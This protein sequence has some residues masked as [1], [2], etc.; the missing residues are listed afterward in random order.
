MGKYLHLF[1]TENEFISAYTGDEYIEP[2]VSYCLENSGVSFNKSEYEKLLGTPLTFN[3]TSPGTIKW[4]ATFTSITRTIEYKLNDGEWAS[5]TSNTG[6]SAPTITVKT[7]D[8]VQFRGN[9]DAY[10]SAGNNGYNTFSGTTAGFELEGNIMSLINKTKYDTLIKLLYGYNF[11]SLFSD[12]NT[13]ISAENL[14]LPAT[15]LTT[16]CY[17]NMFYNCTSLTTPPSI[18]PATT[19][20]NNCYFDMFMSCYS[21]TTAPA[22]PAT[23]LANNCYHFMFLGCTSLTTAP[24]LPA[25]TLADYCYK[26]MFYNCTS[27]TTAPELPATTL[28]SNCYE[29]MFQGCTRLN[30]IKCLATN[31]SANNCVNYWVQGVSSTGT[32]IKAAS[33]SS[34]TTGI[35]GIPNG[36]TVQDAS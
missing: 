3:I 34:W 28:A 24:E 35:S 26:G 13:L 7:G 32:F 15:T 10:S 11:T 16:S 36:W 22:L 5:I 8:K 6:N 14:I 29:S 18:L 17:D 30:H 2:W 4:K 9:N 19:L 21:L 23:T 25:T 1:D 20:A 31:I 33:M 12:C 27:L